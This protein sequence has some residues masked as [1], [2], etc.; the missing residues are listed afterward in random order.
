MSLNKQTGERIPSTNRFTC[1]HRFLGMKYLAFGLGTLLAI[2]GYGVAAAHTTELELPTDNA[3][4]HVSVG[5]LDELMTDASVSIRI[6]VPHQWADTTDTLVMVDGRIVGRLDENSEF[7]YREAVQGPSVDRVF[8][9]VVPSRYEDIQTIT[10]KNGEAQTVTFEL[11]EPF[12]YTEQ[13]ALV[14]IPDII[15][16]SF[17]S[18]IS[19][20]HNGVDA[21]IDNVS[22][23]ILRS[24]R[25]SNHKSIDVLKAF[26]VDLDGSIR[27]IEPALFYASAE[28]LGAGKL[29]LEI[30][31]ADANFLN[32]HNLTSFYFANS[33]LDIKIYPPVDYPN[34]DLSTATLTLEYLVDN[35]E[36]P[37]TVNTAGDVAKIGLPKG[38]WSI[39][40][41]WKSENGYTYN[42]AGPFNLSNPMGINVYLRS[43]DEIIQGEPEFER[44]GSVDG[45][46]DRKSR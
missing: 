15:D 2:G 36:F 42:A 20:Q 32:Y 40:A 4:R 29:E 19:F 23:A 35:E 30:M 45:Q 3:T 13:H 43:L 26:D 38:N 18:N 11:G 27:L 46:L 28:Q 17:T 34:A 21:K 33:S 31:A 39:R 22:A 25:V 6:T 16:E 5:G 24:T 9:V 41:S 8:R 12:S 7:E 37:V 14:G 1:R 44:I 10:L